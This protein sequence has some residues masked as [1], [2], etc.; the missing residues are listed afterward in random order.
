MA[1]KSNQRK[2]T[3]L[4]EQNTFNHYRNNDKTNSKGVQ[5]IITTLGTLRTLPNSNETINEWVYTAVG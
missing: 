3:P 5:Q 4:S 1:S 2:A